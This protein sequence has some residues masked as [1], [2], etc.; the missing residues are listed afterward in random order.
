MNRQGFGPFKYFVGVE[1]LSDIATRED[2][3][4]VVNILGTESR[5]VTPTSH[6]YSG[7]NVV[8]GTQPGRGGQVLPTA[9][10][11]IPVFNNV[12]EGLD[13]GHRFDVGVVYLPPAGVR[14]AVAELA[15][16][17]PDLRKVVIV[18]EKV[19]VRAARE[20]R[21]IAQGYGIDVFGA[22]CLGVADSWNG[23]RI[24]GAL[25]GDAPEESLKPGSVAI[26]SNS[27]NFTTTIANY[28]RAEG[29]APP[30]CSRAARTSTS[31]SPPPSGP[32]AS[33]MTSARRPR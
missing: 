25:G 24:G 20:I 27:G 1:K 14:D 5:E 26:Y 29:W 17:N 16:V 13:A 4:C 12:R 28:L 9:C 31:T 7:G 18:T 30:R 19:P 21:A 10:G 8:F 6:H 32:S 15:R 33:T 2:R 11:D 22:N 23:V 3:V